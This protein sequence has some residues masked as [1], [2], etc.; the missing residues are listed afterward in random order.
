V[1][2][3][4]LL[5]PHA[6]PAAREDVSAPPLLELRGVR[7]IRSGR[8]ILAVPRLAIA[9]GTT[10]VLLGANGAGKS[11]LLRVAAGLLEPNDGELRL[12][13]ARASRA[14]VRSACAAVLQRPILRRGSVR[15]NVATGLRFR[16]VA[17]DEA[18]ARV[19]RWIDRLGLAE[20]ARC[21][22][23]T[24]SGGEAQ[25]VSLARALAVG[26]RLLLLDE[27]FGA[28]DAPTRGELLADLR[29]VLAE[30][31]T[32]TLLVTHDRHEA[33]ALADEVAILHEGRVRQHG[34]G[35][36]VLDGPADAECA[37]VLGF[38][39]VLPAAL[40]GGGPGRVAVRAEACELEEPEDADHAPVG[41]GRLVGVLRRIVPLGPVVRVV[42]DVAGHP[43]SATVPAPGPAWLA[44]RRPGDPVVV[45]MPSDALRP[46]DGALPMQCLGNGG[47]Q[48]R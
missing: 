7:V 10:T 37:R 23:H 13:G 28:L 19:E 30:T 11:T 9:P 29:E 36:A 45:R 6:R 12:D 16:R 31:G 22:A 2:P 1:S 4:P 26:P 47:R 32:A 15:A 3:S 39:N 8:A 46:L 33:E 43:V 20:L 48:P 42:A 34:E 14:Q 17:R 27:P 5:A 25:R 21:P 18:R 44:E 35:R 41:D 24:L 40:L 38:A